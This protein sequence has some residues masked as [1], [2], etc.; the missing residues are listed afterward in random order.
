ML[1]PGAAQGGGD[2]RS[3]AVFST[4]DLIE[5]ERRVATYIAELH[6]EA[7][8]N[9]PEQAIQG[10]LSAEAA[11]GGGHGL[12]PEQERALRAL[13]S[14]AGW[15]GTVGIA[16]SGKTT[17]LRPAVDAMQAAGYQVLGVALAGGA[18]EVLQA[19]TGAPS[20]NIA[21][22]L[23]RCESG[24]LWAPDGRPLSLGPNTILLIDEGGTVE[25]T[26]LRDG[27]STSPSAA[28][29]LHCGPSATRSRH[30][31]SAPA[32]SSPTWRGSSPPRC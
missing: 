13:C 30:S 26:D 20:W 27:S 28:G 19:E 7:T 32:A 25:L 22:F 16:G 12:D 21:D 23:V 4:H 9:V 5:T 29:S 14:P 2:P 11:R 15:A 6:D 8:I 17:T 3:D 10:A 24:S 1:D 31:R 18:A